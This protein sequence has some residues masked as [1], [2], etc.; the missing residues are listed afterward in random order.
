MHDTFQRAHRR[1]SYRPLWIATLL[2]LAALTAQAQSTSPPSG[3]PTNR[4][5]AQATS[6]DARVSQ[7]IGKDVRN[8]QGEKLGEIN[9]LIV[10]VNNELIHYAILSFGGFMG[11]GD[12]LFAYP[13]TVFRHSMD[14][15]ELVLD[16]D[17]ERLRRAPGFERKHWPDWTSPDYNSS[18]ERHFG[19]GA[20]LNPKPNAH[21][22]RASQLMGKNVDDS[23][24]KNAGEVRD[25]VVSMS[26]GQLRYAVLEFDR[27]WNLNDRLLT[28]PMK[29]LRFP[30]DPKADLVVLAP[31]E[32]LDAKQ[33]FEKKQWPDVNDP[34]YRRQVDATLDRIS[35]AT[36]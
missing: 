8:P 1:P 22:L 20:R 31:R 2:G 13:I 36:R 9:D 12:K 32:Q 21:L 24:G 28:L 17:K 6:R 26:T 4:P 16:I 33:G 5:A 23:N 19:P 34:N 25:L 10:D 7:L 15:D 14:R 35:T 11:L 18:L 29:S 27:S 30:A 3:T